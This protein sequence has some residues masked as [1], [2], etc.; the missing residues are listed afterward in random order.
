MLNHRDYSEYNNIIVKER[1][2]LYCFTQLHSVYT[3][4]SD[5]RYCSLNLKLIASSATHQ[6]Y[7]RVHISNHMH[8]DQTAII[9]GGSHAA[10]QLVASLRLEGWEGRI[11]V[12][13][14]D[15]CLPYHR[16][17]LSK[18]YLSGEKDAQS[19]LIR[20]SVFYDKNNIKF[21]LGTTVDKIDRGA[22]TVALSNGEKLA[23]DKLAICTG[24]RVRKLPIPGTG[25]SGVHYLRN[26]ADAETIKADIKAG[27]SAAIIGGGYIGLETA[28]LLCRIGMRVTILETMER[29]LE[30]VTAPEVGAFYTRVHQE[31][32]VE[33]KTGVIASEIIG[34]NQ[35]EA[36]VCNTG[37]RMEADLV[38][39]G[40]GVVPNTELAMDAGLT[41]DNG[42]LVDEY[43]QTSDP[44]IVA[45]GDCT[46]HPNP[47][48]GRNIRLESVPNATD[49]AKSAAASMCGVE[50]PYSALPWF[51]SDQYDLKLQI[52]GLNHGFDQV[53]IRGDIEKSRSF[54]AWYLKNGQL[55][56]ADCVNRVKEFMV[57]K[58]ALAGA[59]SIDLSKLADDTIDPKALLI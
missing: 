35:V 23:Y 17:P 54:V 32:G 20:A 27:G 43:A 53:I 19:L 8:S 12:I 5:P 3:M 39:I 28:A 37:E 10:S 13:S 26:I 41:V 1:Q 9:I 25:F 58:Q 2:V 47:L 42:I 55:I 18:T 29:V 46:N 48:I 21:M 38:I 7:T 44:N 24:A 14:D 59:K 16:P 36:V 6:V 56:A 31:E 57:A 33:I 11:I 40:I 52:A 50:K 45:A 34:S 49:Q 15:S 4:F 30:R 22:Q 51:W